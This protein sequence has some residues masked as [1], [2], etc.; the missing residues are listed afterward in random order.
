MTRLFAGLLPWRA[1][2][3][4]RDLL[5]GASVAAMGIPQVLGYARIAGMPVLSG[6]YT[7]LLPLLAFAAFGASRQL[8]VAADSATAAIVAS[9]LGEMAAPGA[10]AYVAL[11]ATVALLCAA[12]LL[13][14]RLFRLGFLADFLSRTVLVGFLAGVGIQVAIAMLGDM[15]ALAADARRPLDELTRLAANVAHADW[16]TVALSGATTLALLA[17]HRLAPRVPVALGVVVLAIAASAAF[18]FDARGIGVVGAV[19]GALA[20]PG[21][22]HLPAPAWQHLPALLPVAVS[23]VVVIIAQSAATARAYAL[24]HHQPTDPNADLLG[25]AAAN[26]AAG[27]SGTFVVNGSPTQT[28]TAD[29]AGARSQYAS[30]GFAGV[31]LLVLLFLTGP[32]QYLPRCVLAGVV[33]SIGLRMVDLRALRDIRRESPGEFTLALLTAAAVLALGVE[34]G[35]VMAVTLSLLRHVRHSYQPDTAVLQHLAGSGW[36]GVPAAPGAQTRPGLVLYRFGANLFYA[37]EHLFA[38]QVLALV[39]G[40]PA[41]V[42]H[43]VVDASAITQL[44]YSAARSLREV[45]DTLRRRGVALA[46]GRVS[47]ELRADMDRHRITPLIGARH[48]HRNLHDAV[49]EADRPA[50]PPA[51]ADR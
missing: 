24:R 11:A 22:Q 27:A 3:A 23:C 32:L 16:R 15:L 43:F 20:A 17:G 8:I 7:V 2:G 29:E 39:D 50:P 51:G 14:A 25:L 28:E 42:R 45:A 47:A 4:G 1:A 41:P 30:L 49:A 5:A 34:Q 44:D 13:L 10:A 9:R 40:A 35:I 38:Q 12:L 36:V 19:S 21:W 26:L 31:T 18:D 46:F 37:N 6:L 33:F 48:L